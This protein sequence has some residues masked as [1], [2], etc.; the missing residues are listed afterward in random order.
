V[1]EKIRVRSVL[2]RYLEHSRIFAFHN[3]G[4]DIIYIGSADMM[5][6]NLDR[7]IEV[8]LRITDPRH[9]SRV[10]DHMNR[11]MSDEVSSW[12]LQSSGDWVRRSSGDNGDLL[13]D[14]QSETMRDIT[15]RSKAGSP[16]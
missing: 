1:S 13:V 5:H 14:I 3:S 8:L 10:L 16:R 9:V 12:H 2:G 4:D 7:R 15:K 6:R 11:G